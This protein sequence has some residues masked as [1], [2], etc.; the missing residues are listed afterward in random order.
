MPEVTIG[1]AKVKQ[2]AENER[3]ININGLKFYVG[4][5][6]GRRVLSACHESKKLLVSASAYLS[7]SGYDCKVK[8]TKEPGLWMLDARE[9]GADGKAKWD[10]VDPA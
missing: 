6:S 9:K 3:E 7:A 2:L 5:R 8:R 10:E 4:L 1:K